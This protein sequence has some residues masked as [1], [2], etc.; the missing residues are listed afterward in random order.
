MIRWFWGALK[1]NLKN[2]TL[3]FKL[4]LHINVFT[5]AGPYSIYINHTH[6]SSA[7][8]GKYRCL[9]FLRKIL[10][11]LNLNQEVFVSKPK[12]SRRETQHIAVIIRFPRGTRSKRWVHHYSPQSS[13][14]LWFN[15]AFFKCG[16][17]E[18]GSC[19]QVV[20]TSKL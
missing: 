11:F 1:I 15:V 6:Y 12:E 9:T 7:Y 16:L 17:C 8:C 14:I 5:L 10:H 18:R 4:N 13:K 20:S 3:Q 19:P 2:C